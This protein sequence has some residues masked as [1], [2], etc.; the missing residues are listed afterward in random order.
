MSTDTTTTSPA[1]ANPSSASNRPPTFSDPFPTPQPHPHPHPPRQTKPPPHRPSP[2]FTIPPPLKRI[3]DAFP[4]LTY[5]AYSLP[6]RSPRRRDEHALFV[7]ATEE[8]AR[9][10]KP[11]FN[12]GCLR[13]QTYLKFKGVGFRVVRSCNHASPS[14]VL[15]FVI[16]AG[17]RGSDGAET[18]TAGGLGRWGR[19]Q[20][21]RRRKGVGEKEKEAEDGS[22]GEA[23]QGEK[24]KE[25]E[26]EERQDVRFEMYMSLI[27]TRIRCAWLH[28]L[29]HTRNLTTIIKPLYIT[30]LSSSP[31]IRAATLHS[32]LASATSSLL[33]S[34][35]HNIIDPSL[36]YQQADEAFQALDTLLGEDEWF[37]GEKKPGLLDAAV[38]SYTHLLLDERLGG[39]EGWVDGRLAEI[40]KACENLVGH[41]GRILER[42]YAARGR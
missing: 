12:P 31:I 26:F 23:E 15:P 37:F 11:S 34:S 29:Y 6:Y 30:P 24:V 8:G 10:G 35:P 39:G 33:T 13:W 40:V 14:G 27:D 20:G 41:R 36:L 2:Y 42:Y 1:T 18:V 28:S 25:H 32:L 22:K 4:L 17:G 9:E 3:F 5:P 7:F 16:P 38:F 21:T 19:E